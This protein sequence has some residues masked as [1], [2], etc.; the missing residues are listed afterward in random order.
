MKNDIGEIYIL[1]WDFLGTPK[2]PKNLG[3]VGGINQ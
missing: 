3:K 1:L 2:S